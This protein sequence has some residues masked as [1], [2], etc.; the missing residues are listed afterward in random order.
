VVVDAN[1]RHRVHE[2]EKELA[3][4]ALNNGEF[5]QPPAGAVGRGDAL[6]LQIASEL[7]AIVLS[8]DS[9]NKPGES[10]LTQHPWLLQPNRI[11][12]HNFNKATGWI[13]TPRQLR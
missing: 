8:N 12:G 6:L 4:A 7:D 3:N 5:M 13:F 11:I 10:F 2:S 1:F 9:F